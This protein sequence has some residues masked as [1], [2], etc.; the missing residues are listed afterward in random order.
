MLIK[1]LHDRELVTT[2][3]SDARTDSQ[4][5][6]VDDGNMVTCGV[7]GKASTWTQVGALVGPPHAAHDAPVRAV[8]QIGGR[9]V[10]TV[11]SSDGLIKVWDWERKR[12]LFDLFSGVFLI[13]TVATGFG[14][15]AISSREKEGDLHQVRVWDYEEILKTAS[16]HLE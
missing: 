12:W 13:A 3:D 2:C 5:S 8:I 4:V 10:L 11:G 7:D 9:V 16:T 15:L 6:D 1:V 14:K